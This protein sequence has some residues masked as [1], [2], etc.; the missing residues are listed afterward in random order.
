MKKRLG[1]SMKSASKGE[2]EDLR[3][4]SGNLTPSVIIELL[5]IA[6]D[7]EACVV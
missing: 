2:A 7:H 1:V 4:D 6:I 3:K 5:C